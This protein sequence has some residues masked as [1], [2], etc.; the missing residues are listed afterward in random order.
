MEFFDPLMYR[1]FRF[2]FHEYKI[3]IRENYT[4]KRL[5]IDGNTNNKELLRPFTALELPTLE[6]EKKERKEKSLSDI[7]LLSKA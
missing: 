3:L 7:G 1:Y 5:Q 6:I 4:S 2:Y